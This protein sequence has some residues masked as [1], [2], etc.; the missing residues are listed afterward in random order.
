MKNEEK[1][2]NEDIIIE[3]EMKEESSFK[4]KTD[5]KKLSE[6]EECKKEKQEYL[7]GW[8]R[9]R[10]EMVNMK[11]NH[12]SEKKLFTSIGKEKMLNELVPVLDNFDAA[13]SGE[14]WENVD[15]NWRVGVEY[16]HKQ[17]VDILNNNGIEEF[18]DITDNV[19]FEKYEVME[20]IESD[21]EKGKIVKIIQKGY[22]VGDKIIRPA[23]IKIAK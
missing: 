8:Q 4:K 21:L 23:K 9:A 15:K 6:A 17:F 7:D 1:N 5:E 22:R 2:E 19:D 3:E 13:F 20:E 10:A 18:G 16:I 11:K 14:A 12:E